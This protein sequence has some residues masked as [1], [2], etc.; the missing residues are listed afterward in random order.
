M[1]TA[2]GGSIQNIVTDNEETAKRMIDF[3]KQNK[4]GRAT[5]LPL[6]SMHGSGGIR[7]AE[8]L[9]RT[10][11][12][13]TCQYTGARWKRSSKDLQISFLGGRSW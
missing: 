3:L 6:T 12:D 9:E 1:E 7:N 5:F 13:R 11:C 10:G 8:A 2:L 4:F